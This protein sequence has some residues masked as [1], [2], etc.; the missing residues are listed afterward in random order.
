MKLPISAALAAIIFIACTETDK[1]GNAMRETTTGE[2]KFEHL[3]EQFADIKILRYRI[4]GF[5]QL[6]PRQKELVYYLHQAGLCGRDILWDQNYKHNLAIRRTLENI[7]GTYGGDRESEDFRA[8]MVYVKR[9]WFSNGIHHHYSTLKIPP[10]FP[11]EYFAVLAEGSE[12]SGF[13]L[14]DG[15]SV[16]ALVERLTPL[17]F[18]PEIDSRRVSLDT[19]GDLVQGSASNFYEGVTRKEVEEFYARQADP[20]NPTPVSR[21]LNS[22]LVKR[23]GKIVEQVWRVGGMYGEAIEKIVFWLEKA[24]PV[25]ENETQRKTFQALI[26]YYRTGDLAKFDEYSVIWVGDTTST[27]DLINGFIETYG[28]ALGYRAT[29]ES[30]VYFRD[31]EATRRMEA[32]AAQA[33]WFEDN[34]PIL[35]RH[36]KAE[37]TGVTGRVVTV[38]GK[39]GDVSPSSPIGINLP[40]ADWIRARHGSKSI[41]IGNVVHAHNEVNRTSG[42]LEEFHL[43]PERIEAARRFGS[44]AGDLHVDLHEVIGHASG[45]LDPGVGTPHETL[46]NYAAIIEEARADL[47]ALYYLHDPKLVEIGVMP[48]LE[49]GRVG[50]DHYLTNGLLVQLARIQ[51]GE[52]IEQT[53][54]RNRALVSRWVIEKGGP[55]GIVEMLSDKGKTYV[56]IRDYDGLRE[57]FGQLLREI[58]RIKSGGDYAAAM[59]L[60][61]TYGVKIDQSLH[62]EVLDRYG[63]LNIAPYSGFVNPVLEPVY[64]DEEMVDVLVSQPEDFTS[65][66]LYYAKR[67]SFLPT[68]N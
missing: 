66:M 2:E 7:V 40:N 36:K 10:G 50:Y 25:A 64:R 6:S 68:Y 14:E 32:V 26:D 17:M 12:R 34:S 39:A 4:P 53:H 44:L 23:N 52:D 35:E 59:Y 18:D 27:V 33:Q 55:R 9:V 56:V 63:K 30:L 51:P 15:E 11:P 48:S 45:Q 58:Q 3:A 42:I 31:M 67:Y 57:L 28:D 46:K 20:D 54:M 47:V 19:G 38:A 13:P 43:L 16:P 62:K 37:V 49:V 21:G 24:L 65:Q 61:E 41:T 22:R 5:E 8:F 1:A 60:V 29:Y